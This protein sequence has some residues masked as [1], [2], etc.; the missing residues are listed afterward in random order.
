MTK[1]ILITGCSKVTGIGFN[2]AKLLSSAGHTVIATVRNKEALNELNRNSPSNLIFKYLDLSVEDSIRVLVAEIASKYGQIDVL[3]N[4]AGYGLIGA[5]EQLSAEQMRRA[6]EVN[7]V[8]TLLLTQLVIPLMKEKLSGHIITVSSIHNSRF[9]HPGRSFYRGCKAI[10][11]TASE[12][13]S[14]EL[15]RWNI[16]VTLFEPGRLTTSIT[17]EQGEKE[18]DS[19]HYKILHQRSLQWFQQNTPIPQTGF[20]VAK[21][22]E[23]L[24]AMKNPPFHFQ[25]N[26]LA[27]QYVK[28]WQGVGKSNEEMESL[29]QMYVENS[30]DPSPPIKCKL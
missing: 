10:L 12:A 9:C 22:L 30:E 16:Y 29:R 2:A 14:F 4:N 19:H 17:K 25:P 13:M 18:I 27:N 3:I 23:M 24:V 7:V 6:L 21:Q 8:G 5:I 1:I 26:E 11:E 28:K 15:V 20:D